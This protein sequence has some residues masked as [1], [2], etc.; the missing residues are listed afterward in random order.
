MLS[1]LQM[2]EKIQELEKAALENKPWQLIG[3]V[4]G[5]KRPDNSLLEENL[6]FDQAARMGKWTSLDCHSCCLLQCLSAHVMNRSFY[7]LTSA[8]RKTFITVV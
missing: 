5:Q 7:F 8:D 6:V 3:E 2:A 4:S 1:C